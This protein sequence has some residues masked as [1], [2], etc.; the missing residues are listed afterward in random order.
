M[1]T[2]QLT[3]LLILQQILQQILPLTLQLTQLLTQQLTLP[4]TLLLTLPLTLQRTLLLT[5]L[6]NLKMTQQT[7]LTI[8]PLQQTSVTSAISPP[9]SKEKIVELA[10]PLCLFLPFSFLQSLPAFCSMYD[11]DLVGM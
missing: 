3:L 8:L 5:Q 9:A 6:L 2:L 10:L 11:L 7:Q 4:L 1:G